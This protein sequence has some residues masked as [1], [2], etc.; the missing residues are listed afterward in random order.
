VGGAAGIAVVDEEPMEYI[1]KERERE[2]GRERSLFTPVPNPHLNLPLPRHTHVY[3]LDG[4]AYTRFLDRHSARMYLWHK[5]T[6]AT[7]YDGR[8]QSAAYVANF[9][10]ITTEKRGE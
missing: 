3:T 7:H 2:R 6:E 4:A 10:I 1:R 5:D 8:V 9:K